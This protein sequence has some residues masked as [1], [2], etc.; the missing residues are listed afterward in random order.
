MSC[1]ANAVNV[2]SH[3][4]SAYNATLLCASIIHQSEDLLISLRGSFLCHSV[5]I[6]AMV[7]LVNATTTMEPYGPCSDPWTFI[8]TASGCKLKVELAAEVCS[9]TSSSVSSP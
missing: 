5:S 8:S 3:L 4:P 2:V 7:D 6:L 1:A 9:T